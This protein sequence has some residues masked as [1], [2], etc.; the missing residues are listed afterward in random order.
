MNQQAP[1]PDLDLSDLPDAD[2]DLTG[3]N[4]FDKGNTLADLGRHEE[5]LSSYDQALEIKPD[6]YQAWYNR[7]I[8]LN[9]LG[10]HEAAISSYD[11][12]LEIK[13][14][15]DEAWNNRGNSLGYMG[16]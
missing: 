7:G 15:D 1:L 8:S 12:A 5:A 4:W 10:R 6:D 11:K 2:A 13:H 14:D 16:R 3:Q 9:D